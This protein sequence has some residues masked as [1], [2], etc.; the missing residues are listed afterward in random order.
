MSSLTETYEGISEDNSRMPDRNNVRFDETDGEG[1][2]G[3]KINDVN[4]ND[5]EDA[6]LGEATHN[7]RETTR[8]GTVDHN[9]EG[10][11]KLDGTTYNG[12]EDTRLGEV[13]QNAEVENMKSNKSD[14]REIE[15]GSEAQ[16]FAETEIISLP[17]VLTLPMDPPNSANL[18]TKADEAPELCRDPPISDHPHGTSL[19]EKD[20]KAVA[21]GLPSLLD[22][23]DAHGISQEE[24]TIWAETAPIDQKLSVD[25]ENLERKGPRSKKPKGAPSPVVSASLKA[26]T[27]FI[28]RHHF[29]T[30]HS[31]R[32]YKT[33]ERRKFERDVYDVARTHGLTKEQAKA[34]V[35]R[36]RRMCGED[37]YNDSDDSTLDS[38]EV[39]DS[40][41]I[42]DQ[43]IT[44]SRPQDG[45][46]LNNT[47]P[48]G[49]Q[50]N[51]SSARLGKKDIKTDRKKRH[52]SRSK[53]E[54][55][56]THLP[57][58]E[59]PDEIQDGADSNESRKRKRKTLKSL[60]LGEP[61]SS[62]VTALNDPIL[63][64]SDPVT[65]T[66]D[67]ISGSV[68]PYME[69]TR[70]SRPR[71]G[72]RKLDKEKIQRQSKKE[73]K[74]VTKISDYNSKTG[75]RSFVPDHVQPRRLGPNDPKTQAEAHNNYVESTK[76]DPHDRHLVENYG[77][78]ATNAPSK[79]DA[80]LHAERQYANE[81][82][83]D[84]SDKGTL[85]D[86]TEQAKKDLKDMMLEHK[87]IQAD[88]NSNASAERPTEQ[89]RH[90]RRRAES[91][92]AP[93]DGPTNIPKDEK[94]EKP[95]KSRKSTGMT[96]KHFPKP[97]IQAA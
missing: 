60:N 21:D 18:A 72:I 94:A 75:S 15:G 32:Q 63:A 80:Q 84:A 51:A 17:N 73:R 81:Q 64:S 90:K 50:E 61:A 42:L 11:T 68:G 43:L 67:N 31:F 71:D 62:S 93:S 44:S 77:L 58:E 87:A 95:R 74:S 4:H 25:L 54:T 28:R 22:I 69:E 38:D 65:V 52:S 35:I 40:T 89:R 7:E 36:A 96:S 9:Q 26:I 53:D 12:R 39:D 57:K 1:M 55:Q 5:G 14:G 23:Y 66:G 8:L 20:G 10:D 3:I 6:K 86:V 85:K 49:N 41:D 48:I 91:Q 13:D 29:L 16:Q 37:M 45:G 46:I 70:N 33:S 79:I 47:L 92:V 24:I 30:I 83:L 2:E 82:L 88:E 19:A 76:R 27:Y 34:Q 97:M 78:N 59:H 56:S